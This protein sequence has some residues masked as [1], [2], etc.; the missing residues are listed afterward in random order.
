MLLTSLSQ[1]FLLKSCQTYYQPQT[2][3]AINQHLTFNILSWPKRKGGLCLF[4]NF[5][6]GTFQ[7]LY[8]NT[9]KVFIDLPFQYFSW[10]K[11]K[12]GLCLFPKFLFGTF[13]YSNTVKVFIDFALIPQKINVTVY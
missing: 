7:F 5:L 4:P 12:G 11:R 8:L 13:L 9:V 6:F 10:P 1:R 2:S 3:V